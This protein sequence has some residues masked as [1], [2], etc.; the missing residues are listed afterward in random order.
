MNTTFPWRYCSKCQ[1]DVRDDG[2]GKLRPS[3]NGSKR[4]SCSTCVKRLK[5]PRTV[6][7]SQA[8]R[9]AASKP[10]RKAKP[11]YDDVIETAAEEREF[12]RRCLG[13]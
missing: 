8:L 7:N 1:Q 11:R 5:P 13:I 12:I 9:K 10:G 4:W 6:S 2:N 3:A